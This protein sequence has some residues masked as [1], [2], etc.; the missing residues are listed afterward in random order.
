ME[1]PDWIE[2]YPGSITVCDAKGTILYM[3]QHSIEGFSS[4]GGSALIG[5]NLL[6]C[7]PE[8]ARSKLVD[9]LMNHQANVYTIEKKG[10]KKLIYQTPWFRDGQFA[11]MVELSLV[12]PFEMPHFI[13]QS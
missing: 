1:L 11:G 7:H 6:D 10:A 9:L 5:T 12:I 13:R 8:P 2:G 4:D 3:N